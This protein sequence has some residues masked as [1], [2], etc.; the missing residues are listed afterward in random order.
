[1]RPPGTVYATGCTYAKPLTVNN[2]PANSFPT[3]AGARMSGD[4]KPLD[5]TYA[6]SY[7]MRMPNRTIYLPDELDQASRSM[8]LNLSRLTQDA[9]TAHME[10]NTDAATEA[11]IASF[12][13]RADALSIDWP[14]DP[15]ATGREEAGER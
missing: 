5:S 14:E 3:T 11:R 13:D 6:Y 15:I 10:E 9:I 1:M 4:S 12:N 2:R 7:I 8:G